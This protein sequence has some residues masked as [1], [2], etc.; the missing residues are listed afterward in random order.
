MAGAQQTE[1][2]V[3]KTTYRAANSAIKN[4]VRRGVTKLV[5]AGI[6]A[7]ANSIAPVVGGIIAAIAT[8]VIPGTVKVLSKLTAGVVIAMAVLLSTVGTVGAAVG[9]TLL[10]TI[11]IVPVTLA[12]FITIINN[13]A[14]LVPPSN[15]PLSAEEL[16]EG[17]PAGWPVSLSSGETYVVSQGPGGSPSHGGDPAAG[18]SFQEAIDIAPRNSG[19]KLVVVTHPGQVVK[20]GVSEEAGIFVRVKDTCGGN[21]VSKYYHMDTIIVTEGQTLRPGEVIGVLGCTGS[22][23][24]GPH[25]HYEFATPPNQAKN[26]TTDA[27]PY[28]TVPFIPSVIPIGCGQGNVCGVT[29]P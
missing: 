27:P 1:S 9:G 17:C 6:Q 11:I 3:K 13:S 12:F 28:M 15:I 29:I 5:Q 7:S 22:W 25:V 24:G 2:T 20:T 8:R 18:V 19:P 10:A 14:Y 4:L 23:C 21:F 26:R 16:P